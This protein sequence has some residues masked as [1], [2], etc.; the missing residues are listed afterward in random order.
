MYLSN[1]KRIKAK[2]F[3]GPEIKRS[4]RSRETFTHFEKINRIW[5]STSNPDPCVIYLQYRSTA[6]RCSL[7]LCFKEN[8][9][10]Q[11]FLK[12]LLFLS[13]LFSSGEQK[14]QG[15]SIDVSF[16]NPPETD[17]QTNFQ[18]IKIQFWVS[19]AKYQNPFFCQKTLRFVVD[20]ST[21][22]TSRLS[23]NSRLKWLNYKER[24]Y[25]IA[26]TEIG[27]YLVLDKS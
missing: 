19:G 5:Q 14:W 20:S 2:E 23:N 1:K 7:F 27:R 26:L 15:G 4:K 16:Q 18:N 10:I 6:S 12:I 22:W 21:N 3:L 24:F 9:Q 8:Y 17:F 25:P 13:D 11:R